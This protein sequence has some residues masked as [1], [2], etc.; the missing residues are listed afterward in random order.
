MHLN[1]KVALADWNAPE[2]RNSRF[3]QLQPVS[4]N[5]I[6]MPYIIQGL[7]QDFNL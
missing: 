2:S 3:S 6:F 4:F 1:S 7:S 5:I